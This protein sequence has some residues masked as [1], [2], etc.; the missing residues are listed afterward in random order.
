MGAITQG[1]WALKRV[2][3]FLNWFVQACRKLEVMFLEE[4]YQLKMLKRFKMIYHHCYHLL[5]CV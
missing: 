5:Q 4:V 2:H 3:N 1:T